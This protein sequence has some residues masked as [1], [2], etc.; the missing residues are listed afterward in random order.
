[1]FVTQFEAWN[2]YSCIE[3]ES[4]YIYSNFVEMYIFK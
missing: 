4:Y 2:P 1:M 3:Y